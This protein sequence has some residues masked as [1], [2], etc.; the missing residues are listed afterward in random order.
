M[1]TAC[2]GHDL[3]FRG[4]QSP[5][6]HMCDMCRLM[7]YDLMGLHHDEDN[8]ESKGESNDEP[9]GGSNDGSYSGGSYSD[10]S[11][12]EGGYSE[13]PS[14]FDPTDLGPDEDMLIDEP[15]AESKPSEV[16]EGLLNEDT[17]VAEQLDHEDNLTIEAMPT[18]VDVDMGRDKPTIEGKPTEVHVDHVTVA[19]AYVLATV[20]HEAHAACDTVVSEAREFKPTG[21]NDEGGELDIWREEWLAAIRM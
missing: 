4:R 20:T 10:G 15:V 21:M 8:N 17:P 16:H 6:C 19:R 18:D 11:H 9:T 12:S 3:P 2:K 14:I 7:R 1:A 13:G 5:C